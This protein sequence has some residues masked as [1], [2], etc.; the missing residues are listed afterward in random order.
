MTNVLFH[1]PRAKPA[2]KKLFAFLV[3]LSFPVFFLVAMERRMASTIN[4]DVV[5]HSKGILTDAK[6]YA[7]STI[8]VAF[9]SQ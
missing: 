6:E 4:K 8:A 2:D 3:V 1:A 7:T 5:E 9:Q